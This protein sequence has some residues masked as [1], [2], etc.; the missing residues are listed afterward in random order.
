MSPSQRSVVTFE[1]KS[2][3]H[4]STSGMERISTGTQLS[5]DFSAQEPKISYHI[6]IHIHIYIYTYI[7]I[8]NYVS[9]Y[10]C[11]QIA[12]ARSRG[13]TARGA[14]DEHA[15]RPRAVSGEFHVKNGDR[16]EILE[17]NW[18]VMGT[19]MVLL[20]LESCAVN[21][22]THELTIHRFIFV[23]GISDWLWKPRVFL[24]QVVSHCWV[25]F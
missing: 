14:G 18:L 19:F 12:E 5:L 6:Y 13:S 11:H 4:P 17:V 21:G 9:E 15:E 2:W 16:A 8:Y 25:A 20:I 24:P 3:W 1:T 10:T 23:L 7:Y 22:G